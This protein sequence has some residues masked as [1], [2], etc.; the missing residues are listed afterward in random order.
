MNDARQPGRHGKRSEAGELERL[1]P[2]RPLLGILCKVGA[3]ISF[4]VVGAL[5]KAA[6]ERISIGEITFCRSFFALIPVLIWVAWEG[7]LGTVFKTSNMLGHLNRALLGIGSAYL[8]FVAVS[9]LPLADA[10]AIGYS[11][12]LLT[13]I[14]AALLLGERVR[15]YRWSAVVLGLAGVLIILSDYVMPGAR[16]VESSLL[17]A[18]C[19]LLSGLFWAFAAIQIRRLHT[20]E[21][22]STIVV[23]FSVFG[24]LAALMTLPF[25]WQVPNATEALYLVCIGVAGGVG[26]V[27]VT[28]SLRLSGLSV[29]AP[30][31]YLSLIWAVLFGVVFFGDVPTPAMLVGAVIVIGAGA[32]VIYRERQLGIPRA[33]VPQPPRS[34][35]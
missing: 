1:L 32:Y 6:S 25:G 21:K 34:I 23:Y 24:S 4:A 19:Q 22:S 27:F 8:G 13:V 7:R 18:F 28:Q 2:S 10:T 35:G 30:F 16:P 33:A 15:I 20:T 17:G 29:L 26:Q 31:D 9:L 14:L 11:S 3:T 5:V 12:P